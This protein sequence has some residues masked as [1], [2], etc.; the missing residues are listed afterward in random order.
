MSNSLAKTVLELAEHFIFETVFGKK[1]EKG[2][3]F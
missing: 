1:M 2:S 3:L